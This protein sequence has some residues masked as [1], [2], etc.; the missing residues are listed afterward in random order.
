MGDFAGEKARRGERPPDESHL[1]RETQFAPA[2]D[3]F[4]I[5]NIEMDISR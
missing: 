3:V 4:E 2:G 5:E 1:H